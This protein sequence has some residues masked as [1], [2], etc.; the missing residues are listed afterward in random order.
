MPPRDS[1]NPFSAVIYPLL[2]EACPDLAACSQTPWQLCPTALRAMKE[3]FYDY[4][5]TLPTDDY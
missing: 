2:Q 4:T 5:V 1:Q 3:T